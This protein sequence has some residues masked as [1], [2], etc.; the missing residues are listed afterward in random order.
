[1]QT[2]SSARSQDDRGAAQSIGAACDDGRRSYHPLQSSHPT[3]ELTEQGLKIAGLINAALYLETSAKT[4]FGIEQFMEIVA[5]ELLRVPAGERGCRSEQ[6]EQ[7]RADCQRL[8]QHGFQRRLLAMP[9]GRHCRY[10][11]VLGDG[12]AW[13]L[14]STQSRRRSSSGLFGRK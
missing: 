5:K 6:T 14:R 7:Q 4:R 2:R 12:S 13:S 9:A 10:D 8:S 11:P 1:M 3:Q